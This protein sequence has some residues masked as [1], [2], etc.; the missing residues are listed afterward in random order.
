MQQIRRVITGI[1]E[2]GRSVFVSDEQ[3]EA[4]VPPL[5]TGNQV[6]ELF[7]A[8]AIPTVPN[9]GAVEE[10]LRFFPT[11]PEGFRFVIFT[12]PPNSE[13]PEMPEDLEWATAETDRLTP[14]MTDAVSDASGMHYSATVDIEYV[15]AGEFTLTLEGGAKK[16]IPA[17][18]ALIQCGANHSWANESDQPATMLLV[19]IGAHLDA[20]RFGANAAAA[21]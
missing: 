12:Y 15:L 8:D 18:T 21:H 19:F 1:D 7:G 16:V 2:Q 9:D 3:V 17:G 10:G 13:R 14:G 6:L 5:L 4:K 11:T 20:S